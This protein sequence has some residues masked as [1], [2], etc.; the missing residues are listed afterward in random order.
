MSGC[1]GQPVFR[2]SGNRVAGV[3]ALPSAGWLVTSDEGIVRVADCPWQVN[4]I[5]LVNFDIFLTIT[6]RCLHRVGQGNP[7]IDRNSAVNPVGGVVETRPIHLPSDSGLE[8]P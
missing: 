8:M 5:G 7:R 3:Q 4:H 6:Y 2:R 1:T